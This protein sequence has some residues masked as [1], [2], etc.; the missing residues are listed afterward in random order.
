[1]HRDIQDSNGEE[2]E[3][4]GGPQSPTVLGVTLLRKRSAMRGGERH[5]GEEFPDVVVVDEGTTTIGFVVS[6]KLRAA[7]V[8]CSSFVEVVVSWQDKHLLVESDEIILPPV[9]LEGGCAARTER[10]EIEVEVPFTAS[11]MTYSIVVAVDQME[12][13]VAFKA[14]RADLKEIAA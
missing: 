6:V 11:E 7:P 3:P 12:T 10:K 13:S 4:E 5:L 1:M 2:D 9:P 14:V 8:R